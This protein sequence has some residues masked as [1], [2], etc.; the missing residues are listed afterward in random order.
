MRDFV[1]KMR[2]VEVAA[3]GHLLHTSGLRHSYDD[4]KPF[5]FF[6]LANSI[7]HDFMVLFSI[8]PT[9]FFSRRPPTSVYLAEEAGFKIFPVL[10]CG[11]GALGQDNCC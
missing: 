4:A 6:P 2:Q 1:Y 3:R 11:Y 8:Q 10:R 7:L 9:V 5:F